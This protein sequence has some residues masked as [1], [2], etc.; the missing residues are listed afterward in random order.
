MEWKS[1]PNNNN[2]SNTINN[3]I[4]MSL[5][6]GECSTKGG[7][8][9]QRRDYSEMHSKGLPSKDDEQVRTAAD[10]FE[11]NSSVDEE[12]LARMEEKLANL[13]VAEQKMKRKERHRRISMEAESLEKSIQGFK[14]KSVAM[15]EKKERVTA[16]SLRAM[17]DVVQKVD[18]LMDEKLKKFNADSSSSDES[19][20]DDSSSVCSSDEEKS[21]KGKKGKKKKDRKKLHKSGKSKK[22]T[23][24][25]RFP[26]LW[27]HSR[28]S[29]DFAGK[30]K[31]YEDLSIQEFCEGYVAIM[32]VSKVEEMKFRMSH[33]KELM[34]LGSKYQWRNVLNYHA[35]C[36]LEIERGNM[37]WGSSFQN[38]Q[39][40]TLA[41]G[42]LN[43]NRAPGS[44]NSTSGAGNN[45]ASSQ[46]VS[47]SSGEG[48]TLFCKLYQRG[49]CSFVQDHMGRLN[50]EN[51]FLKHICAI[52]WLRDRKKETHPETSQECPHASA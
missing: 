37:K 40:T 16:N 11:G 44:S 47:S 2:I 36:L 22:V 35:S 3:N 42:F 33:L 19:S 39:C 38:L 14:S 41:G 7:R 25:V 29:L 12:S 20:E 13:K 52:C 5:S 28:L 1:S 48:P 24:L 9:V 27:P 34:N 50:G 26:Q 23:S 10:E 46:R 17:D 6:D 18:K 45:S 32:E 31:E 49:V 21:K 8:N 4:K 30:S 43:R 15:E 51:K